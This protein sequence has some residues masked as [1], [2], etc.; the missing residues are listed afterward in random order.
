MGL[1]VHV[2]LPGRTSNRLDKDQSGSFR[3]DQAVIRV[4]QN[5]RGC[6][7]FFVSSR[8]EEFHIGTGG[9]FVTECNDLTERTPIAHLVT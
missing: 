3:F 9:H 1:E 2:N 4:Q 8:P 7:G 5:Q 6:R